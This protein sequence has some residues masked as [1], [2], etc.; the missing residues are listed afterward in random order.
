MELARLAE[1]ARLATL[2]QQLAM[3]PS[4]IALQNTRH[5]RRVYVGGLAPGTTEVCGVGWRGVG[6][7]PRHY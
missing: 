6:L 5:A 2:S 3:P 7:I 4:N 1:A